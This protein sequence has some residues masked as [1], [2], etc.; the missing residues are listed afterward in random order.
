MPRLTPLPPAVDA[1][2][3]AL[4]QVQPM[5]RGSLSERRVKC[6][7]PGCPCATNPDARHGPYFSLTRGVK[8]TTVSRLVS[9]EEAP[10]V[11]RQVEAARAFRRHVEALWRACEAWADDELEALHTGPAEGAQ[12]GG[13]RRRSPRRLRPRLPD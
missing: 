13:S 4:G 6:S 9:A 5:R 7:K 2:V 10:V 3:T 8:G 12:K 1:L 11:R